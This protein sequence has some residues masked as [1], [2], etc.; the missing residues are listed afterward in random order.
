M[1]RFSNILLISDDAS[2]NSVALD[3]AIRLARNNQAELT[4][5]AV[6]ES[7]PK[8]MQMAINV[9]KPDELTDLAVAEKRAELQK[10]ID[11]ASE[12]RQKIEI[13]ILVGNSFLEIIRQVLRNNHDLIIKCA[14]PSKSLKETLFGS[15]D[16]HLLRKCPCPVWLIKPS[17]HDHYNRVLAAV[18]WDEG[19][20]NKVNL[21]NSILEM[22]TSLALAV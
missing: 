11:A 15:T 9:I 5:T 21:N 7:I 6:V 18:D 14:E 13:E 16:M 3:R 4:F 20:S 12:L 2:E 8:D 1:K 19:E 17:D 22:A 10:I